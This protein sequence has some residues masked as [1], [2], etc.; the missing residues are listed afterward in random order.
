M[1]ANAMYVYWDAPHSGKEGVALEL[2][3]TAMAYYER[4]KQEGV[5][6]TYQPVLL[7][8][9]G[10]RGGFILIRCAKGKLNSLRDEDEFNRLTTRGNILL[11]GFGTVD[12]HVG[13]S[14]D[15]M[16]QVYRESL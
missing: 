14:L 16:L 7:S 4:K 9:H 11:R 1:A 2:F 6:E 5:I 10:G 3:A 8:P 15:A 13:D 12:A